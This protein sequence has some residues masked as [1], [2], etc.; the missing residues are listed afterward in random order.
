MIENK[1]K[2]YE[3]LVSK[4]NVLCLEEKNQNS[5]KEMK[6]IGSGAFGKVISGSYLTLPIAIK[7]MKNFKYE[8]FYKEINVIKRFHHNYVPSL[9][10]LLK[11][12][13]EFNLVC[14]LIKGRTLDD[15]IKKTKPSELQILVHMIDLATVLNHLH[16]YNIIH[17]DLKPSNIMIDQSIDVKLIDFGISKITQNRSFTST[18]TVGTIL[19]MA[20]ENFDTQF[21]TGQTLDQVAKSKITGRVDVW[22]FGCILSEIFSK[23]KPWFPV[24][25]DDTAVICQLYNKINFPVPEKIKNEKLRN[26]IENCTK[27]MEC[28][29]YNFYMTTNKLRE[30]LLDNIKNNNLNDFYENFESTHKYLSSKMSKNYLNYKEF[31][32]LCKI[33]FYLKTELRSRITL[34][35]EKI[36]NEKLRSAEYYD[37][38]FN[39]KDKVNKTVKESNNRMILKLKPVKHHAKSTI[40]T[41]KKT[42]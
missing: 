29:R 5:L 39:F 19:Y 21:M 36:S 35:E 13:K 3:D 11:D 14:E 16:N 6:K 24:A 8:E 7:K 17:R 26:L 33:K 41:K 37:Q 4:L 25:K 1:E 9:Y 28:H 20:P 15:Y 2:Y 34:L 23:L 22:A 27:V 12:C 30:I 32:L 42:S 31:R 40:L 38:R 18:V 10:F